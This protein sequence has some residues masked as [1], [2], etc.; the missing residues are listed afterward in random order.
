M[1]KHKG[2]MKERKDQIQMYFLAAKVMTSP[3]QIGDSVGGIM[4]ERN[5]KD[6]IQMRKIHRMMRGVLDIG[7][8]RT[9]GSVGDAMEEHR[10]QIRMHSPTA[11]VMKEI[12]LMVREPDTGS[13]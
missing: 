12:L 1:V 5:L 8:R 7:S 9:G 4:E 10:G 11:K 6:Q 3:Q 13:Q 2:Q